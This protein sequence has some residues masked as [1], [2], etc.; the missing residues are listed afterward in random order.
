MNRRDFLQ[1]TGS[2]FAGLALS[3][4]LPAL[5][6]TP[7]NEWRA[8]E[9]T[10]RVELL[11]PSGVSRIWLPAALKRNTPFQRTL[12]D[13][14]DAEGGTA[15][16]ITDKRQALAMV[17]ATYPANTKPALTLTSRVALKNYTVDLSSPT[18]RTRIPQSELDSFLQP[19]RYIPTD[20]VVK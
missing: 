2:V 11:K 6:D 19:T 5:A 7:S 20:G 18:K 15:K 14:F 17:A 3:R 12:S 1:S 16:F 13:H 4:A 9:V 8:F 10:T